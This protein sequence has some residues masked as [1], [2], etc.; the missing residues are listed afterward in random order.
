M[1]IKHVGI[2]ALHEDCNSMGVTMQ[3]VLGLGLLLNPETM[4]IKLPLQ[5]THSNCCMPIC[6]LMLA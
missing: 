1:K 2:Y 6:L 5:L 3:A 4:A